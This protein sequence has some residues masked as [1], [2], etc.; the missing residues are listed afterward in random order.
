[1]IPDLDLIPTPGCFGFR[2]LSKLDRKDFK[3]SPKNQAG[4]LLAFATLVKGGYLR[5]YPYDW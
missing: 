1:M 4:V 3:L 5:I 2:Y